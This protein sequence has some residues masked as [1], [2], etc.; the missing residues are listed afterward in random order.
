MPQ[1]DIAQLVV[2]AAGLNLRVGTST[3]TR[4]P[5][6][7][8]RTPP[9]TKRNPNETQ[10]TLTKPKRNPTRPITKPERQPARANETQ[11][12]RRHAEL[13]LPRHFH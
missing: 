2:G 6:H 5:K 10:P 3:P 9:L 13:F 11:P 1:R 8:S 7:L 12:P 4:T